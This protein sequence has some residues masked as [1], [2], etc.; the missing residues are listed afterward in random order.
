ML[1]TLDRRFHAG[2]EACR[3]EIDILIQLCAHGK[4]ELLFDDAW[5]DPRIPYRAEENRVML[6]QLLKTVLRHDN[7]GLHIV[8]PT[9]GVMGIVQRETLHRRSGVQNFHA[10]PDD[11]R[12]DAVSGDTGDV[13]GFHDSA[14]FLAF[15]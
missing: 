1:R 10:F 8:G 5:L 12:T 15:R 2:P 7:A 3:T 13:V 6:T 11:F 9:V 4:E 14:S